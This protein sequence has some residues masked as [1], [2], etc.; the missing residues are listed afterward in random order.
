MAESWRRWIPVGRKDVGRD[1]DDELGFHIEERTRDLIAEGRSPEDARREAERRF[2]EMS[3][4][5]DHLVA[6]DT[7][8]EER[9]R[10]RR[11]LADLGQDLRLAVRVLSRTP[12]FA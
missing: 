4:I 5:R 7:R 11:W 10:V 9:N 8:R 12:F 3:A 6:D 1:V 2:G